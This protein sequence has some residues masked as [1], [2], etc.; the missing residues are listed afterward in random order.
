[1][2]CRPTYVKCN[3]ADMCGVSYLPT[4]LSELVSTALLAFLSTSNVLSEYLAG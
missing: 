3:R 4:Q 1:M 2:L